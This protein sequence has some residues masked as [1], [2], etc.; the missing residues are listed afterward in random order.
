MAVRIS[1]W[2]PPIPLLVPDRVWPPPRYVEHCANALVQWKNDWGEVA[3][4]QNSASQL[5]YWRREEEG[6]I[7]RSRLDLLGKY[8]LQRVMFISELDQVES[9]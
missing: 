6:L 2:A 9:Y 8:P 1:P 5:V 3:I 4:W 7:L